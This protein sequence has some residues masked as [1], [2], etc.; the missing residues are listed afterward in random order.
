MHTQ[1]GSRF[2]HGAAL[3]VYQL[4]SVGDLHSAEGGLWPELHASGFGRLAPASGA[5][6]DEG[7]LV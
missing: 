7:A 4:A 6:D 1:Q 3:L 5:V 2:L